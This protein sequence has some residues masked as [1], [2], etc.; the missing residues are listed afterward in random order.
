MA[1]KGILPV[2]PPGKESR[3]WRE[4]QLV[5]RGK[6]TKFHANL[7]I[8]RPGRRTIQPET[9]FL[10]HQ[11]CNPRFGAGLSAE[12]LVF[13]K[14]T[15]F[16]RSAEFPIFP[17]FSKKSGIRNARFGATGRTLPQLGCVY[18]PAAALRTG[19]AKNGAPGAGGASGLARALPPWSPSGDQ[20]L[21]RAVQRKRSTASPKL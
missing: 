17:N 13:C 6:D 4:R 20:R 19:R 16:H 7:K 10:Q 21:L 11:R 3:N 9:D 18:G 12:L 8:R 5:A 14:K 15:N 2:Q 1:R